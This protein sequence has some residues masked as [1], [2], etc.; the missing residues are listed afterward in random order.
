MDIHIYNPC[1]DLS[2]SIFFILLSN[3][4][5]SC[6]FLYRIDTRKKKLSEQTEKYQAYKSW[7]SLE[8][9]ELRNGV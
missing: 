2:S 8:L 1:L 3:N 4:Y 6:H 5:F 7:N 9:K